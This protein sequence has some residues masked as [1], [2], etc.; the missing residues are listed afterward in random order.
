MYFR[1]NGWYFLTFLNQK[2]VLNKLFLLKKVL[3]GLFKSE[4]IQL[5]NYIKKQVSAKV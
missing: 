2:I 4:I 3:R 5:K 1:E